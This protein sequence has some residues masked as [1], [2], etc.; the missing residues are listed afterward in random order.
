MKTDKLSV[1]LWQTGRYEDSKTYPTICRDMSSLRP[2][3][4]T[5]L[6]IVHWRVTGA[7]INYMV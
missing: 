3:P 4:L 2:H 1:C 7:L 5:S 6:Y